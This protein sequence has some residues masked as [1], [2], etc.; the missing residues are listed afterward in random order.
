MPLR[1]QKK[2]KRKNR[3]IS[4]STIY[5]LKDLI[6]RVK[7]QVTEGEKISANKF[8]DKRLM[9]IIYKEFLQLNNNN[10]SNLKMGK[11]LEQIFQRYIND[12]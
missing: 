11:G 6:N 2:H 9:S 12:Q 4:K 7:S 10:K 8:S 1:M 5:T 3:Y